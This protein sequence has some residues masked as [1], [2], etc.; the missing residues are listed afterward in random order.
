MPS[1]RSTLSVALPCAMS[2]L[3][4]CVLSVLCGGC[5]S[6]QP[7]SLSS[8]EGQREINERAVRGHAVLALNGQRGRPVRS[9]HI[10]PDS[11]SWIDK[12]SGEFRSAPSSDVESVTFRRDGAGALKGFAIT[13]AVGATLGALLGASDDGRF[14]DYT[15]LQGAAM[16][17]AMGV[18]GALIGAIH[19]DRQV[20]RASMSNERVTLD[21]SRCCHSVHS[22]APQVETVRSVLVRVP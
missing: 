3:L 17:G 19:S 22:T 14:L 7:V 16:G 18:Y 6:T 5:V 20:Y 13:A 10:G 1:C 9:L 12:T 21:V 4:V 15:P 11:T 2:R 8:P